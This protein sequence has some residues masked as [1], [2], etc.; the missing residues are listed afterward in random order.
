MLPHLVEDSR[1]LSGGVCT[2]HGMSSLLS[3]VG[4]R[5]ADHLTAAR[6]VNSPI[7]LAHDEANNGCE[8]SALTAL[9]AGWIVQH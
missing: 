3:D 8:N 6:L 9:R 1:K 2:M 7:T 5:A 4:V